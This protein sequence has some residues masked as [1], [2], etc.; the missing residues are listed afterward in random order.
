MLA[1]RFGHESSCN[2]AS[3]GLAYRFAGVGVAP[4]P[5]GGAMSGTPI[6]QLI[7][8]PKTMRFAKSNDDGSS[9]R[10][11]ARAEPR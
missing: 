2:A 11:V 1:A 4:L 9:Q 8:L 5:I 3:M 7:G 10:D 6:S